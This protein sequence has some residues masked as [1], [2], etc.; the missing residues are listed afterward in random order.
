MG[1]LSSPQQAVNIPR[2]K[3]AKLPETHGEQR[4]KIIQDSMENSKQKISISPEKQD[5]SLEHFGDIGMVSWL[6]RL[7]FRHSPES[8]HENI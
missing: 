6:G 2:K 7:F 3:W 5:G 8:W 4:A 1:Q